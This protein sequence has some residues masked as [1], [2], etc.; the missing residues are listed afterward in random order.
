MR[1]KGCS[2]APAVT[3]LLFGVLLFN[4]LQGFVHRDIKPENVFV[5]GKNAMLGDFGLAIGM[6]STTA[7]A[8]AAADKS[9]TI[10]IT[11]PRS[12][13]GGRCSAGGFGAATGY[14][15][16]DSAA[17]QAALLRS[18]LSTSSLGNLPGA[19]GNISSNISGR[20]Q[21]NGVAVMRRS[22]SCGAVGFDCSVIPQLKQLQAGGTPA[23]T[24]PEVVQATFNNTPL[25][26]AV[27][28]QVR[29]LSLQPDC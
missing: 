12:S 24:A 26:A 16:R 11:S 29:V 23:Y 1:T 22:S 15:S 9:G 14:S 19:V 5:S 4:C 21:P 7:A 25:E 28:P 3:C 17:K 10:S 8:A 2:L 20:H 6:P 13:R 18:C 27:G